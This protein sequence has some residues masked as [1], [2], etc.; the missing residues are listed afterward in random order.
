MMKHLLSV[1]DIVAAEARYH[2]SCRL[3][4]E[5]SPTKLPT[6]KPIESEKH[7]NFEKACIVMENDMELCIV[8][9]FHKLML[10]IANENDSDVYYLRMVQ[11]LT[12]KY[13]SSLTLITRQGKSNIIMLDRVS[14]ILS[15]EWYK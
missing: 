2:N 5:K 4:F 6:G 15:E 12:Q 1:N 9:E 10:K 13:G 11:K 8:N 7:G 3:K 14:S